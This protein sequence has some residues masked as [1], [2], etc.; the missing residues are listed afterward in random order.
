MVANGGAV[1]APLCRNANLAYWSI[2]LIHQNFILFDVQKS[3]LA[4]TGQPAGDVP[5]GPMPD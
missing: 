5:V 3:S 2:L 4:A 1:I